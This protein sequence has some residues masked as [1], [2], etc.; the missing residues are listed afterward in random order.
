[1]KNESLAAGSFNP[2][3]VISRFQQVKFQFRLAGWACEVATGTLLLFGLGS[4]WRPG[5]E[6]SNLVRAAGVSIIA[7]ALHAIFHRVTRAGN[8][9]V[10]DAVASDDWPEW[11]LLRE[12][13][14]PAGQSTEA[15]QVLLLRLSAELRSSLGEK[16][17]RLVLPLFAG[18]V[19][20]ALA[21]PDVGGLFSQMAAAVAFWRPYAE[22][23][24]HKGLAA[25]GEDGQDGHQVQG[26]ADRTGH[27]FPV[28]RHRRPVIRLLEGN[29]VEVS[30]P[31][32]SREAPVLRFVET[33]QDFVMAASG[34]GQEQGRFSITVTVS[35]STAI[36]AVAGGSSVK[37]ATVEVVSLPLPRVRL[38][39][40]GIRPAGTQA[41]AD[42]APFGDA[43]QDDQPL[44]LNI[45]VDADSPVASVKLLIRSGRQESVE[46]VLN[47]L[48]DDKR[49]ITTD[50]D[51]VLEPYIE[52]D[53]A[54]VTLV[55]IATDRAVPK[56]LTGASEP[57][58]VQVLS[59]YG[60]YRRTLQTLKEVKSLLDDAIQNGGAAQREYKE[61]APSLGA[62]ANKQSEES[63]YFDALDR[64]DLSA[65][66]NDI[67][68]ATGPGMVDLSARLNDF[69]FAHES[70]DQRERDRDFF[71][72]MRTLSRVLQQPS[73]EA[74]VKR[75]A[76]RLRDFLDE[77]HKFWAA[78][79][80][81][82]DPG[83]KP[84]QWPEIR[85][86]R[87][88]HRGL[89]E[90]E[91]MSDSRQALARASQVVSRYR[92]WIDEL[93][94]KEDE[95]R[96]RRESERQRGLASAE[97]EL[98]ELQ[99]RQGEISAGL[100]RA[101]SREG[102]ELAKGWPGLRGS[103]N[104]NIKGTRGLEGKVR[105]FSPG[106]EVRL[107]AAVEQMEK[108][109]ERGNGADFPGAE[110]SSDLAGRLLR[111][112]EQA[113]QQSR[114]SSGQDRGR[115]RRVSGDNYYGQSI[116]GGDVEIKRE[117]QVDRKY[118][119]DILDEVSRARS[120]DG[121][122]MLLDRYTREIVR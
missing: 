73:P 92:A 121:D 78:R 43:W 67:Q 46:N 39:A 72:A 65:I 50:Y 60:R 21:R 90:L 102:N 16:I 42:S 7:C 108:T 113:A 86:S 58:K 84:G 114:E 74:Q 99:R 48:S 14:V 12:M 27:V 103:Q 35:R 115:R 2:G 33:G 38:A 40:P 70:I 54:E 82:I 88:F 9:P 15:D 104:G 36:H 13:M 55:A 69:L 22:I 106:A 56:P 117:Y 89:R 4:L 93:E 1:M 109:V 118:R 95:S 61:K 79:V 94:A 23:V 110:S 64:N 44:K 100:D 62:L 10:N 119:E 3:S 116:I 41:G 81:R 57:I 87:P 122:K 25:D 85:D 29:L 101:Q 53:E 37:L 105:A 26:A 76:A 6:W 111:Q 17:R 107:K 47:V 120:S 77:R 96:K 97:N 52:S 98:R 66:V 34:A 5:E 71:V 80:D 59:S 20:L 68:S 31:A 30:L 49:R 83:L 8:V 24:V 28:Y 75:I 18:L 45:D 11:R 91:E 19:L 51:L 63:P 112:A 32:T